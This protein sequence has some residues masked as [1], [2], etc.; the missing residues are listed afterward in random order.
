MSAFYD[1]AS[2]VLVPSGTKA[3]KIY[4]QKPLTTD[5]Q[6][7]FTRSTTATRVNS[8]GLIEASAINVPRLDYLNSS[9]PRLLLEP[10]RT[11]LALYSEQM[12]NASWIKLN[13]SVTANAAVSPDGYTN[14]DSF[15]PN[16]T[17]GIHA[18]RS[19]LF[20][21]SATAAHSWF[22][23]ANGYSKVAVRESELVGN[24]ASFNLATGTL[25][26]TNQTGSIVNY[27]NGWYRL[28]LVDTT[29]GVNAQTSI[30]VL[31]DSYTTG[32]PIF[33]WSGDGTKGVL[34]YGAMVELGSYSTSYIP[35]LGAAVTRGADYPV[36][37][38]TAISLSGDFC[39]FWEGTALETDVMLYGSG[40]STWYA[41]ILGAAG[42]VILDTSTGRKVQATIGSLVV[43]TK[44]QILIRRQSGAHNVF[45]NGVK[46][47][48]QISVNDT[49][50]LSLS[51]MFWAFSS[52]FYRGQ[53]VNQS[54]IF[55]TALSD[56]QC[57]ELTA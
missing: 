5:G 24:Y 23:K 41:N 37:L 28:T 13:G 51:S 48:N 14:A 53:T 52:T 29:T 44:A 36:N 12:D 35:T 20:N 19:N 6:L 2:L 45:V 16:T 40:N 57:I 21:Q 42:R 27:G 7:A 55:Q 49:T 54:L 32:T 34:A 46:L 50:T 26:S 30:V 43:G 10:Q 56:A 9:C 38:P 15:V 25:I 8:A 33:D 22:V 18:L 3:Q 1:L 31:P 39:L 11:N 47:T 17:S 4:A